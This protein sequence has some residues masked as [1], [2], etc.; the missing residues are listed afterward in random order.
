MEIYDFGVMGAAVTAALIGAGVISVM[1]W[2]FRLEN[3]IQ[4]QYLRF[5]TVVWRP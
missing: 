1:G 3:L 5:N 2:Y 4:T